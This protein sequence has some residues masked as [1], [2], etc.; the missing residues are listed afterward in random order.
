MNIKMLFDEWP[1]RC[2]K[3][4]ETSIGKIVKE[5]EAELIREFLNPEP[6]DRVLDAGC[7]TGIST[8]G[9]LV[10]E[11]QVVGIDISQ[12]MLSY[13]SSKTVNHSF[14]GVRGD[15]LRLSFHDNRFDKAVPDTALE[16]IVDGR[17]AVGE[18]F[19]VTR[20]GGCV[21]A[22]ILNS[23]TQRAVRRK[24]KPQEGEEHV[25]ERAF[26]R[27]PNELL[28]FNPWKGA[29]KTIIHFKEDDDPEPAINIERLGHSW[30]LDTGAFVAVRWEKP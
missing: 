3:W 20:S 30:N 2:D 13:A 7:G 18:P 16:F 1:A 12:S 6:E 5:I 22:A 21:A 4:F 26:F 28:A 8:I 29:A 14:F 10:A 23:L 15:M 27:S 17:S 25:W 24:A 19:R 11:V 9:M